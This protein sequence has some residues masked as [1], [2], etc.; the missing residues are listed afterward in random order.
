M[1]L[2][3]SASSQRGLV[4]NEAARGGDEI[5]VRLHQ[6]NSRAPIMPRLSLVSGQLIET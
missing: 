3:R 6:R 5:S 4:V 1:R 2:S